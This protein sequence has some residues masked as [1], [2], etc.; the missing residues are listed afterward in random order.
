MVGR[1]IEQQD[2]RLVDQRLRQRRAPQLAAGQMAHWRRGIERQRRQHHIGAIT[3]LDL[4][5]RQ[6]LQY[7]LAHGLVRCK[8]HLLREIPH[9]RTGKQ[10]A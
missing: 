1:L 4:H 9:R 2:I 5:L 3:I 7:E 6:P 10:K 8:I